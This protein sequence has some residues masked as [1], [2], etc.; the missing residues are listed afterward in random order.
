MQRQACCRSQ[1]VVPFGRLSV[2]SCRNPHATHRSC[3]ASPSPGAAS[4][5]GRRPRRDED[6]GQRGPVRE[7]GRPPSAV[8]GAEAARARSRPIAHRESGGWPCPPKTPRAAPVPVQ[9]GALALSN[10]SRCAAWR[11]RL[12]LG[13]APPTGRGRPPGVPRGRSAFRHEGV[14]RQVEGVERAPL[15]DGQRP[16]EQAAALQRVQGEVVELARAVVGSSSVYRWSRIA[17]C[18]SLSTGS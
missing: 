8:A 15:V 11:G 3:P 5:T 1:W 9:L 17:R 7:R 14:E 6:A 13:G 16:P 2:Q 18:Q 12:W 4:P 10:T